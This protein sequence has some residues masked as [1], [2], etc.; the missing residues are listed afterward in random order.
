MLFFTTKHC[1]HLCRITMSKGTFISPRDQHHAQQQMLHIQEHLHSYSTRTSPR[2]LSISDLMDQV[3]SCAVLV[4]G[5]VVCLAA[6]VLC[7]TTCLALGQCPLWG[8]FGALVCN[9]GPFRY[10]L[11]AAGCLA[12]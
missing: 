7:V 6:S 2:T 8:L 9:L 12:M 11:C 3:K 1:A 4:W 10:R 5:H